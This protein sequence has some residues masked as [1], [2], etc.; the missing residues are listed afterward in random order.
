MFYKAFHK[1]IFASIP[2]NY[3]P[4]TRETKQYHQHHFILPTTPT[5]C[6]QIKKLFSNTVQ[7]WNLLP[8]FLIDLNDLT[9]FLLTF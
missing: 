7:E 4:M 5:T 6:Y 1:Q 9:H 2:I 8:Q 3:L